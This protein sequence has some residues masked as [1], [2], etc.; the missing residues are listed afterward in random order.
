MLFKCL[1]AV[2]A[3]V[4]PIP[5]PLLTGVWGYAPQPWQSKC[6]VLLLNY[7][8]LLDPTFINPERRQG[9][10][11]L[12]VQKWLE[13]VF[14]KG[15]ALCTTYYSQESTQELYPALIEW[16][17]PCTYHGSVDQ[18]QLASVSGY[19]LAST[20]SPP[21]NTTFFNPRM[22]SIGLEYGGHQWVSKD[23]TSV[24]QTK[25]SHFIL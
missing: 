8:P 18:T 2:S 10:R 11:K 9:E 14:F 13:S 20:L 17:K 12:E 19:N 21:L 23:V 1:C 24:L 4:I 6:H 16:D 15:Q 5:P 7:T 22:W 3:H 25:F